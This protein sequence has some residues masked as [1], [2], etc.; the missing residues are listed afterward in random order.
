MWAG[1]VRGEGASLCWLDEVQGNFCVKCFP[2]R[3]LPMQ[4]L[5]R[6]VLFCSRELNFIRNEKCR[7]SELNRWLDGLC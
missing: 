5:L 2:L 7:E 3:D 6:K 4:F 1:G